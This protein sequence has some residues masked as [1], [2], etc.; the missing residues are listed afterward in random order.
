MVSRGTNPAHKRVVHSLTIIVITIVMVVMMIIITIIIKYIMIRMV[1]VTLFVGIA[2]SM[3][4]IF[5][6]DD[7]VREDV[8]QNSW[9]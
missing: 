5:V 8:Q 1:T 4:N 3:M 9:L 6:A 2:V 7:S